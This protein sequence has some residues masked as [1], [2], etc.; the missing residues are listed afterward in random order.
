MRHP[1]MTS[2]EAVIRRF[3]QEGYR[4]GPHKAFQISRDA[5]RFRVLFRSDLPAAF[6]ERFLLT[7]VADFQHAIGEAVAHLAPRARIGIMPLA[8]ATIPVVATAPA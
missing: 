7:P 1:D 4:I 8:N 6:V 5:S 3:S 2:H